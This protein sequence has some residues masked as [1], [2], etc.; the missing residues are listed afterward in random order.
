MSVFQV[1]FCFV[2]IPNNQ[3]IKPLFFEFFFVFEEK[4]PR[5]ARAGWGLCVLFTLLHLCGGG[6]GLF[7]S[8]GKGGGGIGGTAHGLCNIGGGG[9]CFL[10]NKV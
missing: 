2:C 4:T 10:Y 8:I 7:G 6:G 1:A 9:L 3:F 5:L